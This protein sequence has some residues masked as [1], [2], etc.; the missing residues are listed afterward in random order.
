MLDAVLNLLTLETIVLGIGILVPLLALAVAR[1]EVVLALSLPVL[2]FAG[3]FRDSL[4]LSTSAISAFF[5]LIAIAGG[6]LNG[7]RFRFGRI[8]IW[9]VIL[10]VLVLVSLRYSRSPVYGTEKAALILGQNLPLVLAA[11]YTLISFDAIARV[12]NTIGVILV[13]DLILCIALSLSA[14][15]DASRFEGAHGVIF[16]SRINA[17]CAIACLYWWWPRNGSLS[18]PTLFLVPA[19]LYFVVISGT[20]TVLMA[21]PVT[22]LALMFLREKTLSKALSSRSVHL[23]GTACLGGV[24]LAVGPSILSRILPEDVY[25][26]RFASFEAFFRVGDFVQPSARVRYYT[27]AYDVVK[28][29]PAYGLG[30][31]G[32][33]DAFVQRYGLRLVE[34]GDP[35]YPVYPHNIFL[36]FFC[37]QGVLG[38]LTFCVVVYL[39]IKVLLAARAALPTLAERDRHIAITVCAFFIYGLIIAQTSSH[40]PRQ[41]ILWWGLGLLAALS[42]LL[43]DHTQVQTA[44]RRRQT[45]GPAAPHRQIVSS[46]VFNSARRKRGRSVSR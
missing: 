34:K 17:W 37:E 13:A 26:G 14:D 15:A 43:E 1:P 8:E 19:A 5:P 6:L 20:R 46:P 33:K 12:L 10:V 9:L 7:Y 18:I 4:P 41:H 25:A 32:F 40:I 11:S 16:G 21:V 3:Q 24:L 2:L 28:E 38:F 23:L 39:A 44:T 29:S 36:E 42:N 31:G 22:M 30:V 35:R 45:L 27:V